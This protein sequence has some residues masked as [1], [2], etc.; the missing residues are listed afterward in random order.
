MTRRRI[1]G[2]L[3]TLAILVISGLTP[4]RAEAIDLLETDDLTAGVN[5]YAAGVL[6]AE[7]FSNAPDDYGAFLS[8]ARLKAYG[9]YE[10][11]A[12]V[13]VQIGSTQLAGDPSALRMELLDAEAVIHP[14]EPLSIHVGKF[15]T[16][17]SDEF[18]FSGP[19]LPFVGRALLRSFVP[20][21]RIGL[22]TF[23][24]L[25]ID[26]VEVQGQVGIFQPGHT[27][28]SQPQGALFTA[29]GFVGWPFGLEV[30][31]A[32]GDLF[33]NEFL[34]D[35]AR[36]LPFDSPLDVAISYQNEGLDLHLEGLGVFDAPGDETILAGYTHAMY[37]F[38][39]EESVQVEP[40]VA[41][42]IV[43][44][45]DVEHRVTGGVNLYWWQTRFQTLLDYRLRFTGAGE[46]HAVFLALRG[47]L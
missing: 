35:G 44:E 5:V 11:L 24:S 2:L 20:G 27:T 15:K 16:P 34:A 37:R 3:A 19:D 25:Q 39:G 40:G 43:E 22:E 47:K 33:D 9:S 26:E 45:G 41:Y 17:V 36:V 6:G 18:L 29:R 8:L 12:E 21:R 46:R 23:A 14:V 13:N 31:V 1:G 30:H 10:D 38:G 42:D 7:I 28:F 4:Q 32:Y